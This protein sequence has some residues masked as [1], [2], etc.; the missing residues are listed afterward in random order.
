MVGILRLVALEPPSGRYVALLGS[1]N[2][3]HVRPLGAAGRRI[4]KFP[5]ES[6][7]AVGEISP[8]KGGTFSSL[9]CLSMPCDDDGS[10]AQWLLVSLRLWGRGFH[11]RTS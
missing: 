11:W 4:F 9:A 7:V 10:R 3:L 6:K 5:L 1:A 8:P 2:H